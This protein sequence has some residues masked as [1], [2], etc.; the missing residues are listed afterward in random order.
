MSDPRRARDLGLLDAVDAF[1]REPFV[2]PVWRVC[3][4]GRD[5]TL[6]APS[7]SR[8]CNGAFDVLYT[9]STR[10]GALSE[11]HALL[12][13][14]PVFPSRLTAYAHRLTVDAQA[15]LH[16]A[17]L[18]TLAALGVDVGRYKEREYQRTQEIADAAYFLGF[19]GVVAPSARSAGLNA[20]FF[21][22]RLAPG[23]IV[24]EE[25]ETQPIDWAAWRS[26]RR[27]APGSSELC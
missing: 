4:E 10:D 2:G 22:D 12:S 7:I 1:K 18:P 9:S 5:P 19:Q 25:S 24:I 17:D 15:A 14:Q 6:G 21:T 26:S 11:V 20:I 8:W 16:L 27:P 3:R 13:L 23:E